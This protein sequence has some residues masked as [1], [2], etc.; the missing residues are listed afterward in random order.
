M[1]YST[2]INSSALIR[3]SD[4]KNISPVIVI[5]KLVENVIVGDVILVKKVSE[6]KVFNN[7][8][9]IYILFLLG[10]TS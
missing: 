6:I 3:V 8:L 2:K 7:F 5:L 9:Y 1:V 10:S 4:S